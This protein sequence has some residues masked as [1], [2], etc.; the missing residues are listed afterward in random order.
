MIVL[1]AI[2]L[3][4]FVYLL[5]NIMSYA[6]QKEFIIPTNDPSGYFCPK[7][8]STIFDFIIV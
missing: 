8:T 5:V 6:T 2:G 3:A 1:V 7:G 4:A